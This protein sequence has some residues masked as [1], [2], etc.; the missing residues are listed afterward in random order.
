[1]E[2]V[3]KEE[4]EARPVY[5]LPR[6]CKISDMLMEFKKRIKNLV[7]H[8]STVNEDEDG[9]PVIVEVTASEAEQ[10]AGELCDSVAYL[11][12][13][14]LASGKVCEKALQEGK[15]FDESL[16]IS[17]LMPEMQKAIEEVT[18]D[19]EYEESDI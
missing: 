5:P 4:K 17:Y 13:E 18:G 6:H 15:T 10:E 14:S 11:F 7:A 9:N 12:M 16:K 19:Y 1:M 3:L 2:V 8:V